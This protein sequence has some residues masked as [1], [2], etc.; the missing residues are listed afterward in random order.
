MCQYPPDFLI[1][2]WTYPIFTY[3]SV[4]TQGKHA[5]TRFTRLFTDGATSVVTCEP[6]T[7][8]MHQIRVHLQYLGVPFVG[9]VDPIVW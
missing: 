8:R 2:E 9:N 1:S 5:S 6:R 3:Q 4:S 7:G